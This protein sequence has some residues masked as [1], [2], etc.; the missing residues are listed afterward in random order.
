MFIQIPIQIL[1]QKSFTKNCTKSKSG[2]TIVCHEITNHSVNI[3]PRL[4]GQVHL[5]EKL[6]VTKTNSFTKAFDRV[7]VQNKIP[8]YSP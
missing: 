1:S 6:L 5:Q 4:Q 2:I 7:K 8:E 3:G